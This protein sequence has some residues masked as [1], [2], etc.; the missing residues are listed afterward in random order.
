MDA[1]MRETAAAEG[2]EFNLAGGVTGNTFDAHRLLH[3]A[4]DRGRQDETI[5]R[6][7]RAYF[8][9]Q[10]SVFD[11]DALV[12]LAGDAGLDPAEV[13]R[14]L[15]GTE[16]VDAVTRDIEEARAFGASG[17]P[18]FVID[19]RYGVSGAQPAEVFAQ[20]LSRAWADRGDRSERAAAR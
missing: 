6:L 4:R 5:E 20:A 17:V 7:F 18:F 9:E 10:R 2:L 12:E 15:D 1:R 3:L 13:R 8:T 14:V 16:Y 19:N 11:R